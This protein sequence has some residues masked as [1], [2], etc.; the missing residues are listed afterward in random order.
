MNIDL[1]VAERR[2]Q[3]TECPRLLPEPSLGG[4]LDL[5][6][7]QDIWGPL[8]AIGGGEL[9]ALVESSGLLGRGGAGFPT[10]RKMQT[11]AAGSG[12]AVIVANGA[13]GEPASAKDA[14]LLNRVPHLVLDGI[15]LAARA[16]GADPA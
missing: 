2:W 16:V 14:M 7:H 12:P 15:Q 11:V 5:A 8:P 1:A 13:E 6:H 10:G 3:S 9:I 4:S